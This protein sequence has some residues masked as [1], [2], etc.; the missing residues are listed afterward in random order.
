MTIKCQKL[1]VYLLHNDI[2]KYTIVREED[3]F[4]VLRDTSELKSKQ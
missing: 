4:R 2:P 1:V 3:W